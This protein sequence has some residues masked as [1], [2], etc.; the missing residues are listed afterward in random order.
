MMNTMDAK[1]LNMDELEIVNGGGFF[2]F[3]SKAMDIVEDFVVETVEKMKVPAM[4]VS[5][6][7]AE[8]LID[9]MTD[10]M[11]DNLPKK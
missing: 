11:V 5:E 6:F 1:K 9:K 8:G 4:S 3:V 7:I 10:A 2:D